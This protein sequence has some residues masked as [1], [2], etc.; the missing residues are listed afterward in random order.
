MKGNVQKCGGKI[1]LS[2]FILFMG[3]ETEPFNSS[4]LEN[5]HTSVESKIA[6]LGKI[7]V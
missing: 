2:F 7:T 3:D 6:A 4:P 1:V 5:L